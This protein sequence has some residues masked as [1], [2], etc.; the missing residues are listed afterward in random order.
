MHGMAHSSLGL[1]CVWGKV[2]QGVQDAGGM[3]AGE[4]PV[5]VSSL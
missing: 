5:R 1:I 2:A 4:A 3:K